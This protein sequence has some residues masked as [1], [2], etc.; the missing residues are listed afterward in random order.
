MTIAEI[1]GQIFGI[2][3]VILGFINFQVKDARKVVVIQGIT[4]AVFCI[5]YILIGAISGFALNVVVLIRNIIYSQRDRFPMLSSKWIPMLFA[6]VMGVMGII[7]WVNWYSV[8][9]VFGLVISSVCMAMKNAQSIRK[10]VLVTSPMV[11]IYNV[12][13]GSVGGMIYESM[14]IIS[15]VIG[16]I[17]HKEKKQ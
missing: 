1:T 16:L 10:S 14:V 17:K 9:V 5:H 13:I 8:F 7:S 11:L 2:I 3:A 4:A 15:S 12:L 6:V